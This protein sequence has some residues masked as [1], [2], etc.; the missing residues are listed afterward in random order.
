MRVETPAGTASAPPAEPTRSRWWQT[1][2]VTVSV[3]AVWATVGVLAAATGVTGT[4]G[5]QVGAV[6]WWQLVTYATVH[7]SLTHGVTVAAA[8][9]VAARWMEHLAGSRRVAAVAVTAVVTGGAAEACLGGPGVV[10]GGSAAVLAVAVW[11]VTSTPVRWRWR[12]VVGAV[13]TVDVAAAV[14]GIAGAGV[15]DQRAVWAHVGGA[16]VGAA[17][18]VIGRRRQRR[19]QALVESTVPPPGDR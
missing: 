14:T 7:T 1:M 5:L 2:P 13:V 15:A 9:A 4:L 19:V 3:V 17:A 12:L 16:A 18:T 10:A 8:W 6:A 11:A